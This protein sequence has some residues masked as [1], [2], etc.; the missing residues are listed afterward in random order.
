[1]SVSNLMVVPSPLAS[2]NGV[3]HNCRHYRATG[4]SSSSS[5]SLLELSEC[6]SE[7]QS[8]SCDSVTHQC[9]TLRASRHGALV[10]NCVGVEMKSRRG[11]ILGRRGA[12]VSRRATI[13]AHTW[14]QVASWA[15]RRLHGVCV[16]PV[17]RTVNFHVFSVCDIIKI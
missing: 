7:E 5:V 17:N 6:G 11:R 3:E 2:N 16:S 4:C 8:S 9:W 13:S 1:M 14:P 12:C 15:I 10:G